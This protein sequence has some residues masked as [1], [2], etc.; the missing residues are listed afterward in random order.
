[1]KYEFKYTVANYTQD[2]INALNNSFIPKI[3]KYTLDG[4]IVLKEVKV[5][6]IKKHNDLEIEI[7]ALSNKDFNL[8]YNTIQGGIGKAVGRDR[9]KKR[10]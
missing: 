2:D 1:M 4:D 5:K 10:I 3:K 9:V 6:I 8:L 7:E